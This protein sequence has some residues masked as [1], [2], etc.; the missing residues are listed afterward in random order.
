MWLVTIIVLAL[1][2]FFT[3]KV[4]KSQDL[5]KAAE[6]ENAS[7]SKIDKVGHDTYSLANMFY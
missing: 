7:I 3:M 5:R 4:L 1:A 2:A 6:K